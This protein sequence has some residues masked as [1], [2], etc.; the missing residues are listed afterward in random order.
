MKVVINGEPREMADGLTV[1]GL[2]HHLKLKEERLAVERNQEI[3][4]R[5]EWAI[6]L[7]REGDKLE[8]VHFVGGGTYENHQHME[9]GNMKGS[10]KSTLILTLLLG[11]GAVTA[12]AQDKPS[13]AAPAPPAS[14]FRAEFLRQLDD[15]EKKLV[16]L[17]QAMPEEKYTW[18]PA[19]GVRSVSEV[20]MHVA[21]ANFFFP[22]IIGIQPPAGLSR[23]MEK[24]TDKAKVVETLKQSF[25]H[26]RQAALNTAD[27]DLDKGVKL[28][29][30]DST[31]RE[32]LLLLATH[33]HEHLGQSIAYARMNGVVPPWSAGR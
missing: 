33:M 12:L 20:Y 2:I 6:T 17:A 30:R 4:R 32:V 11:C 23:E 16:D 8:I 19:E 29:G 10:V 24:I 9:G 1:Q 13:T 31:V 25:E 28:F 15:A 27:A 14:G 26:A 22:R 18:R 21:G 5:A 3:V 7:L